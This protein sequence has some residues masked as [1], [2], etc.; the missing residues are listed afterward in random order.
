M[1][2]Y[3]GWG[4]HQIIV[5]NHSTNQR[6]RD[7]RGDCSPTGVAGSTATAGNLHGS[8]VGRSHAVRST[9]N[10]NSDY[11]NIARTLRTSGSPTAPAAEFD[12]GS[13]DDDL[14]LDGDGVVCEGAIERTLSSLRQS[15]AEFKPAGAALAIAPADALS[16][17]SSA[18]DTIEAPGK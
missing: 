7:V 15:A 18:P 3:R 6:P 12:A 17:S 1:Y 5:C 11:H 13:V 16:G 10:K 8:S 14:M 2:N 9:T 4:R